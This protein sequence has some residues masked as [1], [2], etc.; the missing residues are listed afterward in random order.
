MYHIG[1]TAAAADDDADDADDDA[2]D[3]GHDLALEATGA[4]F[5]R[6][7]WSSIDVGR[8][9]H[10]QFDIK[11]LRFYEPPP[12]TTTKLSTTTTATM[13]TRH[14]TPTPML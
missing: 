5:Y 2:D 8:R 9:C 10:R 6:H 3:E 1:H 4:A 12:P 11:N 14:P 7:R 13:T